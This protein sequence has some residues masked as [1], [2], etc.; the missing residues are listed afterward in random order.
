MKELSMN[1]HGKIN[2]ALDIIRK[3]EDGY[4]DI[5]SVMQ[6]INLKDELEFETIDENR[7]E[8]NC[9]LKS[10]PVDSN[11]LVWKAWEAMK[12]ASGKNKGLVVSIDKNIP[13]GAGLAGG[14]T[15]AAAT[16]KAINELW[17]LDYDLDRLIEIGSK[18]GADVPFCLLEG[19]AVAEGI[20]EKLTSLDKLSGVKLL[21]CNPGIEISSAYAYSKIVLDDDRIDIKRLSDSIKSKDLYKMKKDMRNKMEAAIISENPII[22]KIKNIMDRE[23][24]VHSLMSGSGSTVF[25]IY[26]DED[27][28]RKAKL[29]LDKIGLK[30]YLCETI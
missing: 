11:N 25:G 3:R 15:N 5:S 2:L 30:T 16:L 12:E 20:G 19:T 7:I 8:I 28:R 23:G 6:S 24:S 4:H 26:E 1:S 29:E 18:I 10:I 27:L 9:N 17:E 14:S 22:E 21:L 13:V